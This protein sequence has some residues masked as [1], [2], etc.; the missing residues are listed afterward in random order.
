MHNNQTGHPT[1]KRV[2]SK[3]QNVDFWQGGQGKM[4]ASFLPI[5]L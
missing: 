3:T 4:K 1:G 5:L 2:F